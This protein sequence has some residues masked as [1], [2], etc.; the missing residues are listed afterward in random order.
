MLSHLYLLQ[1]SSQHQF[2][3]SWGVFHRRSSGRPG[4]PGTG[5]SLW[6]LSWMIWC[7]GLGGFLACLT[8]SLSGDDTPLVVLLPG[9]EARYVMLTTNRQPPKFRPKCQQNRKANRYFYGCQKNKDLMQRSV[10]TLYPP[11]PAVPASRRRVGVDFWAMECVEHVEFLSFRQM[12]GVEYLARFSSCLIEKAWRRWKI[13]ETTW[14]INLTSWVNKCR[15][16]GDHFFAKCRL[17]VD[18]LTRG[19]QGLH[20]PLHK[21]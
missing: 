1:W 19:V 20:W 8:R 21:S 16:L 13:G 3:V 2:C 15:V 14:R 18:R 17:S 5:F 9:N 11:P 6:L 7:Y 4:D 12:N 10:R